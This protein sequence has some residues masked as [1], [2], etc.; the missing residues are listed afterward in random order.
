MKIHGTATGGALSKKDF[1]VAFG[2]AA[3]STVT[4]A[5]PFD[6]SG[7]NWTNDATTNKIQIDTASYADQL[8]WVALDDSQGEIA[9]RTIC[10]E[11]LDNAEWYLNFNQKFVAKDPTDQACF[12]IE[13]CSNSTAMNKDD[14]YG[15]GANVDVLGLYLHSDVAVAAKN[16]L[17]YK[18]GSDAWVKSANAGG[19]AIKME[20]G[21]GTLYFQHSRQ[22]STSQKLSIFNTSD[23]TDD[24]DF[25]ATFKSPITQTIPST[26]QNLT[27]WQSLSFGDGTGYEISQ[28]L[29][30][31]QMHDGVLP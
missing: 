11:T 18:D 1:G 24:Y 25:D 17:L 28:Q 15:A 13:N 26:V 12:V 21:R 3:A 8:A 22:S 29:K 6:D 9:Y 30:D 23:F 14:G 7:A 4:C 16:Y 20:T 19:G 27:T 5:D 2:G 31:L 10:G